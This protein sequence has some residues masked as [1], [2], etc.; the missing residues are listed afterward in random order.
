MLTE[1]SAILVTEHLQRREL[2]VKRERRIVAPG[3]ALDGKP[4]VVEASV[5]WNVS[6]FKRISYNDFY[7]DNKVKRNGSCNIYKLIYLNSDH[8][9]LWLVHHSQR[10][11]K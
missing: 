2:W 3:G 9:R 11:E 1:E 7:N 5:C 8:K 6:S 4:F 10:G